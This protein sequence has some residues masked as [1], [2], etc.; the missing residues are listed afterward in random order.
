MGGWGVLG[1]LPRDGDFHAVV[2]ASLT[3]VNLCDPVG[4]EEAQLGRP[5]PNTALE[6]VSYPF[7]HPAP[8]VK[9]SVEIRLQIPK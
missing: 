3:A 5:T 6:N 7:Y 2:S 1:F 9:D 4:Q 8:G